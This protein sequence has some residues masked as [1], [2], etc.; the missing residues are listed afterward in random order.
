MFG[1]S[2]TSAGYNEQ[3]YQ[4]KN[5]LAVYEAL[6]SDADRHLKDRVPMVLDGT[7]LTASLRHAA[8]RVAERHGARLVLVHC[9]CPADIAM[10]RIRDRLSR[11]GGLSEARPDL[12]K[13]QSADEE[14]SPTELEEI[15]IDT[16]TSLALNLT[17]YSGVCK[18]RQLSRIE[19][20]KIRAGTENVETSWRRSERIR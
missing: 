14:P 20:L 7:F 13:Q 2:S 19:Q 11:G 3:I 10:A 12:Y 4:P 8:A 17:R 9:R 5:R 18:G 6:F 16:T 1:T 15:E